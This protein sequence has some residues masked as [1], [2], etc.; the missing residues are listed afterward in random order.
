DKTCLITGASAGIGYETA[1]V[2]VERGAK[3]I[4]VCRNRA[5]SEP[6]ALEASRGAKH[7]VELV[8][9]DLSTKAEIERAAE[10]VLAKHERLEVLI[11]NAGA[12]FTAR[13]TTKDGL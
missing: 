4:M 8:I 12:I 1:R 9:A 10:E 3:V 11:N 6:L 7:P 5:K 13:A 2:L